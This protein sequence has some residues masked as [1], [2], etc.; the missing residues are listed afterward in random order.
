MLITLFYIAYLTIL[1]AVSFVIGVI[2]LRL[3]L[4]W[5]KAQNVSVRRIMLALV[6]LTLIQILI[7]LLLRY[8]LP[9][10]SVTMLISAIVGLLV[11]AI[12]IPCLVISRFFKISMI[13]SFQADLP[14]LL[15][16]ILI[17]TLNQFV[18]RPYVVDT[19]YIPSNS[20]APTLLGSHRKG[21]CQECGKTTF[22]MGLLMGRDLKP[23]MLMMICQENFHVS[24]SNDYGDQ[25]YKPD[26]FL[27]AKFMKPSRW[28][29]IVYQRPGNPRELYCHRLVGLPGEEI[30]IKDGSVWA[31][32]NKLIPPDSIRNIQY[33]SESQFISSLKM[34]GAARG[35]A[36]L[37]S[38]EY[39]V[40]GDFSANA[41]DS[42]M[43]NKGAPGHNPY[44]VPESYIR[45]VAT[46]IYWPPQRSRMLR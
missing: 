12:L 8:L 24:R 30:E 33:T 1:L 37:S 40:L 34:W 10:E 15:S 14:L 2:F 32:G 17:I 6:L 46:H 11:N 19:F 29:V 21:K 16:S 42:R 9:T 31:D 43:W 22:C 18:L 41:E 13:R 20:M 3:G 25:I 5:A 26:R 28:D 39:F 44:A 35:P 38:D 23:N 45:G 4:R 36:K 7:V 27:V